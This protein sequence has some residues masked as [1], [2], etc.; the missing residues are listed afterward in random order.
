[1]PGPRGRALGVPFST[2]AAWRSASAPVQ[3]ADRA[4][5]AGTPEL[6]FGWRRSASGAREEVAGTGRTSRGRRRAPSRTSV[7]VA[8]S[9]PQ[10][11]RSDVERDRH[12]AVDGSAR[13]PAC[14]AGRW[15]SPS[16]ARAPSA[17]VVENRRARSLQ[18][19]RAGSGSRS[20]AP[21]VGAVRAP[22]CRRAPS[23]ATV[24]RAGRRE[25]RSAR[26][27]CARTQLSSSRPRRVVGSRM[28]VVRRRR[29]RRTDRR[30]ALGRARRRG[31]DADALRSYARDACN[32]RAARSCA[33]AGARQPERSKMRRAALACALLRVLPG[34][35]GEYVAKL[36][37][38]LP[39]RYG[40]QPVPPAG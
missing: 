8:N 28:R 22:A 10:R 18:V 14:R 11:P 30:Q 27:R 37:D 9:G 15:R 33:S 17:A 34:R 1:M 16:D 39:S 36:A 5:G 24:A 26:I 40:A 38:R 3:R 21:T 23:E 32:A 4:S 7:G 12:R 13:A 31:S 19:R 2:D 6:R 25:A 29:A 35:H 20:A